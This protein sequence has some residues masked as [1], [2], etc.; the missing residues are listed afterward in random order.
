MPQPSQY[1][2]ATS[3]ALFLEEKPE[4]ACS[5]Y[6]FIWHNY[7]TSLARIIARQPDIADVGSFPQGLVTNHSWF[8]SDHRRNRHTLPTLKSLSTKRVFPIPTRHTIRT[9]K[10]FK[11]SPTSSSSGSLM[12][13]QGRC[14]S[15]SS[16]YAQQEF[17]DTSKG[18]AVLDRC[19]PKPFQL[20][21]ADY[22]GTENFCV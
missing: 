12:R 9:K 11:N 19:P 21:S 18:V 13:S 14:G 6:T 22:L 2:P 7:I 10:E 1:K 16:S 17:R 20:T 5:P 3:K 4:G 15:A 8:Q